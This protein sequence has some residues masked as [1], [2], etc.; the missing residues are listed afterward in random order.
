MTTIRSAAFFLAIASLLLAGL[1][2]AATDTQEEG[3]R[4]PHRA[5]A[6]RSEKLS[7]INEDTFE[8]LGKLALPEGKTV[9]WWNNAEKDRLA[10]I[11]QDGLLG[12]KPVTLVVIDLETDK[13]VNTVKLGYEATRFITSD[14]GNRGYIILGGKIWRG[15][16]SVVVVDTQERDDRGEDRYQ[17]GADGFLP[18][19]QR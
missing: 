5:Y 2:A 16:P 6:F 17:E 18:E 1:P 7:I 10:L 11:I 19:R 15:T 9:F 12:N 3:A 8:A 13:I 14:D 4:P